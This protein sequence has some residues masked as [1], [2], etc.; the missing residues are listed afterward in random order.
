[1]KLKKYKSLFRLLIRDVYLKRLRL[2][3]DYS[4][5]FGNF[6]KKLKSSI[7]TSINKEEISRDYLFKDDKDNL[8]FLDVGGRDGKLRYLL[9][10]SE[11]HK[12]N[13]ELY[14]INNKKFNEKYRYFGTDINPTI[15]NSKKMIVGDICQKDYLLNKDNFL[16]YF[17]LVYSNNV[18]EHLSNP[19]IA[20]QN[21]EKVLKPGGIVITIA[22]FS[23]RYHECPSDY[24][25][26][27]HKGL[28]QLFNDAG[29]FETLVSGYDIIG[30][31]NNWQG[32]GLANDIVPVDKF[33]AW[34][35]NWFVL[36]IS[37]KL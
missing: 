35:E 11:N 17:D 20:V 30:R 18:F 13:S 19:F 26:F 27:T 10:V 8:K 25:R 16:E 4:Y 14:K 29:N 31:R 7:N 6:S 3:F 22:P 28:E 32:D 33:G 12:F 2:I 5:S 23:I 37:K 34:R 15:N 9:G 36:N 1:M 24:F 21:I